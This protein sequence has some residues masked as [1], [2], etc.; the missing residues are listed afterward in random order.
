VRQVLNLTSD[1]ARRYVSVAV[2]TLK[3]SKT[4]RQIARIEVQDSPEAHM[5]LSK[6][7]SDAQSPQR[8][9]IDRLG[10]I[11]KL[12]SADDIEIILAGLSVMQKDKGQA[13]QYLKTFYLAQ[14]DEQLI[15]NDPLFIP[16]GPPSGPPTAMP[17]V[18]PHMLSPLPTP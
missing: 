4:Q 1:E 15:T 6:F 9:F 16:S 3:L 5:W 12:N 13:Y 7:G 17:T 10:D 18:L 14:L 8:V 11:A 2:T